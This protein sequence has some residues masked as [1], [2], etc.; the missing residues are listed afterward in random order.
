[1]SA[2]TA[3]TRMLAAAI[4][5]VAEAVAGPVPGAVLGVVTRAGGR[6]VHAFGHAQTEPY[7]DP[8]HRETWFDLA[9][10]TK[11][12]FTAPAILHLVAQERIALG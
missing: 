2:D 8:M 7:P 11:V 3:A 1:M 4:G 9:S 10:L 6:A 5:P 12:L